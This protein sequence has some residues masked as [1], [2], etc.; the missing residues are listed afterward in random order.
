MKQSS[1]TPREEMGRQ[2]FFRGAK[3]FKKQ[4]ASR[5]TGAFGHR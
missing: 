2:T 3:V 5:S 1:L 4:A